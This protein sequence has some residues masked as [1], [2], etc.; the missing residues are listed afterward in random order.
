MGTCLSEEGQ[1]QDLK[2]LWFEQGCP[3]YLGFY[4]SWWAF[5]TI[6]QLPISFGLTANCFYGLFSSAMAW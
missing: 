1:C 6:A 3:N 5:P 2:G 4:L